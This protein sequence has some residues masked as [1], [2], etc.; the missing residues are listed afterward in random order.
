L[1]TE[2]D[3]ERQKVAQKKLAQL[4]NRAWDAGKKG[5]AEQGSAPRADKDSF[6]GVSKVEANGDIKTSKHE[7]N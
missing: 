7:L 6:W 3:R 2:V 5:P 4:Q 1:Q